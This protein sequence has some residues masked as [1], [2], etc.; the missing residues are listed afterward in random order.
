MVDCVIP[1]E[2]KEELV[3][4]HRAAHLEPK[5]VPVDNRNHTFAKR[6]VGVTGKNRLGRRKEGEHFRIA[7]YL[8]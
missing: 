6:V 1:V 7:E 3:L 2:Q 5:I 8:R 4:D